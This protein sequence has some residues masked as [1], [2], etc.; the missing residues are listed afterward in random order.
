MPNGA[1]VAKWLDAELYETSFRPVPLTRYLKVSPGPFPLSACIPGMEL[2]GP[3]S[4]RC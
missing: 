1:D 4:G 2:H 3:S